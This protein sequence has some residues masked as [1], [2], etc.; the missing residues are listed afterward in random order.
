MNNEKNN[1][2]LDQIGFGSLEL[3]QDPADFCYGIDAVILADF[4]SDSKGEMIVDL[5]CGNGVIPLILSHKTSAPR[6]IGVEKK[7]ETAN[8][9]KSNIKL[10]NL[11][12]RIQIIQSDIMDISLDYESVDTIVTNPPYVA[13][14]TGQ[15]NHDH[16]SRMTA[17]HETTATLTDFCNISSKLL[18]NKG[19][20]YM[21]HRPS[22]TVQIINGLSNAGLEPKIIR[23]VSSARGKNPNIMLIKAIKNGGSECLIREPL[24]VYN[25]DGTYTDEINRIYERD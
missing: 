3:Y 1:Y 22:R 13:I 15:V 18:K 5:G 2:R 11:E 8:L 16:S 21:V 19:E 9:A 25:S 10:N 7:E 12:N 20:L 24:Y 6:I 17:R 23:Y 4:A 14:G